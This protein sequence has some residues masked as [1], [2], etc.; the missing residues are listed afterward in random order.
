MIRRL[1]NLWYGLLVRVHLWILC[2]V[3]AYCCRDRSRGAE[4]HSRR[5]A[6]RRLRRELSWQKPHL[7]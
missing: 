2:R 5:K 7:N 3:A 6:V 1:D 4:G